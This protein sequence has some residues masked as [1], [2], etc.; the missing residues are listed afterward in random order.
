MRAPGQTRAVV[1]IHGYLFHLT[2]ATVPH[3]RFRDWQQPG[4]PLVR[5]LAKEADRPNRRW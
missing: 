4:S 5:R 1:L 2:S 3:P